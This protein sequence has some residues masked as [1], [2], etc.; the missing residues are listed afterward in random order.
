MKTRSSRFLAGRPLLDE[1]QLPKFCFQNE[2]T[3]QVDL[4]DVVEQEPI[5]KGMR[6]QVMNKTIL[7]TTY[8]KLRTLLFHRSRPT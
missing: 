5:T 7:S 6:A 1:T 3:K 4:K 8:D 2:G